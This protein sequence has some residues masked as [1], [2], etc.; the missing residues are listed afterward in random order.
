MFSEADVHFH[1]AV[2]SLNTDARNPSTSN[3]VASSGWLS[4]LSRS[5]G[6]SQSLA[7]FINKT[8]A[9]RKAAVVSPTIREHQN[10]HSTTSSTSNCISTVGTST[11]TDVTNAHV[12]P[13]S[14]N[15]SAVS[16]GNSSTLATGNPCVPTST[17]CSDVPA[18]VLVGS[19]EVSSGGGMIATLLRRTHMAAVH[20]CS[21]KCG[22]DYVLS[23]RMAAIRVTST[24]EYASR[25]VLR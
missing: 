20:V 18:L 16:T 12:I 9:L 3:A 25:L 6:P 11:H 7:K 10:L 24:G 19:A 2:T 17:E 13:I 22:A 4:R 14:E 1:G 8:T 21:L 5:K 23:T 15:A